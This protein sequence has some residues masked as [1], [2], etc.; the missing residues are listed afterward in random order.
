MQ[1]NTTTQNPITVDFG[2]T[3]NPDGSFTYWGTTSA[4]ISRAEAYQRCP[5]L[6]NLHAA[7]MNH[8]ADVGLPAEV[9]CVLADAKSILPLMPKETQHGNALVMFL[10]PDLEPSIKD[11]AEQGSQV[12]NAIT[13][14]LQQYFTYH[15]WLFCSGGNAVSVLLTDAY[16]SPLFDRILGLSDE[17]FLEPIG[18]FVPVIM[19]AGNT[20]AIGG[21]AVTSLYLKDVQDCLS[22]AN[23]NWHYSKEMLKV[24]ALKA[25][26]IG[27]KPW[28]HRFYAKEPSHLLIEPVALDFR[29]WQF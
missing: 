22:E 15:S 19:V 28:F 1:E 3:N 23:Q 24:A 2:V 10:P 6:E 18:G 29:G 12:M 5:A 9:T 17:S 21:Y 25:E 26:R 13:T 27:N 16:V 4:A 14:D 11:T 7:V 20:V 8:C